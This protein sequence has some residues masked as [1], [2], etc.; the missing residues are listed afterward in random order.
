M[1]ARHVN[2]VHAR[3]HLGNLPICRQVPHRGVSRDYLLLPCLDI[4]MTLHLGNLPI[5]RQVPHRGVTHMP[6][7]FTNLS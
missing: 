7:W 5:C 3:L 2:T 4:H 1:V 6:G